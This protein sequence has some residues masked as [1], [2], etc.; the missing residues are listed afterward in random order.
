MVQ[1]SAEVESSWWACQQNKRGGDETHQQQGRRQRQFSTELHHRVGL[2]LQPRR[3]GVATSWRR[4]YVLLMSV[5]VV[6]ARTRINPGGLNFSSLRTW[7]MSAHTLRTL[8]TP[9]CFLGLWLSFLNRFI[10][11]HVCVREEH[12]LKRRCKAPDDQV[13][14]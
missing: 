12:N 14:P 11:I 1:R 4:G 7:V 10:S 2:C 3:G 5:I 8:R 9:Q 13:W 6:K